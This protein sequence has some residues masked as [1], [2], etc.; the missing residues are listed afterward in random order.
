MISLAPCVTERAITYL[1]SEQVY[2]SFGRDR[3]IM[4][5][6]SVSGSPP[7]RARSVGSASPPPTS[8]RTETCIRRLMFQ[9]RLPAQMEE[10]RKGISGTPRS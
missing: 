5:A 6:S 8:L 4:K 3:R 1:R 9:S 2:S 10:V 7:R